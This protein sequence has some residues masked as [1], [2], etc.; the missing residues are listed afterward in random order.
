MSETALR[1]GEEHTLEHER[2]P[3]VPGPG[4]RFDLG[5]PVPRAEDARLVTGRARYVDNL[6][7]E[8]CL[9][10]VFVRSP[11]AHARVRGVDLDGAARQ[12]G[13]VG[14]WDA[15]RLGVEDL[16]APDDAAGMDQPV[17]AHDVVR[18]VGE[19]VAMVVAETRAA[20]FDAAEHVVVDY[21]PLPAVVD[22]CDALADDAP[23]LYPQLGSNLIADNHR[24]NPDV[25]ADAEVIARGTYVNQRIAPVPME[26]N[27][28][29]AAPDGDRL[30]V[31][32]SGRGPF[33]VRDAIA[34]SL[35]IPVADVRVISPDVGGAF[36]AKNFPQPATIAVAKAAHELGRPVRWVET[37]SESMVVMTQGRSH[38][39]QVA[40]GATRE[41]IITG[42]SIDVVGD[43]GAYPSFSGTRIPSRPWTLG[44][45]VYRIPKLD[46]RA[47]TAVT[48]TT[49]IA[50]VRGA[51][52]PESAALV[53]RS[54]DLLATELG[55]DPAELRRRNF[56]PPDAF[57]WTTP[58]GQVYDSGDYERSLDEAL[59][60]V[61]Y[62]QLRAE[63]TRRRE[64]G[65]GHLLGIGI[66][67]Y[68]EASAGT[69]VEYAEV[70]VAPD[71]VVTVKTGLSPHGQGHET[72][73]AQIVSGMLHVPFSSIR[74]IHSDTDVVREGRGTGGSRSLQIGG[75]AA[76]F[77]SEKLI[78]QAKRLV[79]HVWEATEE[80]VVLTDDGRLGIQGSPDT[81][82]AWAELAAIVREPGRRPADMEPELH[83]SYR[84]DQGEGSFPFGTHVAVVEI[85]ADTGRI[86]LRRFVAVD[87][88][89]VI[90][91]EMLVDGQVHGGVAQGVAQ[92]LYEQVLF[93]GDGN[94]L[95]ANLVSY[96][97]PAAPDLP[98]VEVAAT[99]TPS[100][101]NPLGAKGIGEGG[102]TGSTPAV[103]NAVVDALSHLGV[104][105]IDMPATPERIWRIV[106]EARATSGTR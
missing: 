25:L 56:V 18:H 91:N 69:T 92:A 14:V 106:A 98:N 23:L 30:T 50:S 96:T 2:E 47:R 72:T 103:W 4:Q 52:R 36:G 81:N 12:P 15:A 73:L 63:Q 59:R 41:G 3:L 95:T 93:D 44:T 10:A 85:D 55:M 67:C 9:H 65:D 77:A 83:E 34:A 48:N 8:G 99:E 102:M 75:S 100:P 58:S 11:L 21:D 64:R 80:D 86:T 43:C 79:A 104:R 1:H 17:L 97:I 22:P 88:C 105:N 16:P 68:V 20:A 24:P 76:V 38:H 6:P 90:F 39:Q 27:T 53:E 32:V 33:R 62:D 82:L 26:T 87:D 60:I 71:G 5:G 51:G 35:R 28:S 31:W 66:S 61:G 49:P 46:F 84:F 101:L 40:I 19:A 54:I 13:V 42:I 7:M 70:D 89:G 57:P 94:P 74:V 78:A 45:G 29:M 37:R